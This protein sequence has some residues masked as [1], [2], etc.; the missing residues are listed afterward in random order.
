M[1]GFRGGAAWDLDE[2]ALILGA[3]SRLAS[4]GREWIASLD[5][6]PLIWG[7]AGYSA[8]DALL[9]ERF[10]SFGLNCYRDG[11][12]SV[13]PHHDQ[14]GELDPVAPIALLSLGFIRTM[15]IAS[16][17]R[18]RRAFSIALEPGSLLVMSPAVQAHW[19]HAIPKVRTAVGT[20]ISIAFRRRA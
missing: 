19:T 3:V 7:P 15:R 4:A 13:A 8:V 16:L 18:P 20:R 1:R 10:D 14:T 12:D 6:N 2:L 5:I 11:N 17:M 9:G